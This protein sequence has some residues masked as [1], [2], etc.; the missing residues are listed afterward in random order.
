M[1]TSEYNARIFEWLDSVKAHLLDPEG[2][3]IDSELSVMSSTGALLKD[4]Y[5]VF[6]SEF[7]EWLNMNLEEFYETETDGVISFAKGLMVRALKCAKDFISDPS[8]PKAIDE[9]I[10][11]RFEAT[12]LQ[13]TDG[14]TYKETLPDRRGVPR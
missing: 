5:V 1:V 2:Q 4:K 12:Y 11:I 14:S 9:M 13:Q 7:L 3:E 8:D 6:A 10:N